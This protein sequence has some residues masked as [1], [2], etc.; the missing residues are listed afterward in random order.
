MNATRIP[1]VVRLWQFVLASSMMPLAPTCSW[2]D[3]SLNS[4][5][6]GK[7]GAIDL[8]VDDA[9]GDAQL[10]LHG[11][12]FEDLEELL[13]AYHQVD[14]DFGPQQSIEVQLVPSA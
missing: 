9:P 2:I 12:P 1:T 11:C 10:Q 3:S 7:S 6:Q 8:G 4:W 13:R 5:K 14:S